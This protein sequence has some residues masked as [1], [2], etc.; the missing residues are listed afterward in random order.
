MLPSC[1]LTSST[2]YSCSW[3][4]YSD[5]IMTVTSDYSLYSL[6]TLLFSRTSGLCSLPYSSRLILLGSEVCWNYAGNEGIDEE[7]D[8]G[9]ERELNWSWPF[10]GSHGPS[11]GRI[12][13]PCSTCSCPSCPLTKVT[14]YQLIQMSY[15]GSLLIYVGWRPDCSRRWTRGVVQLPRKEMAMLWMRLVAIEKSTGPD[16]RYI[17]QI[18][19]LRYFLERLT[20]R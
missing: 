20:G 2:V 4:A 10:P 8:S 7:D 9:L 12:D 18:W 17:L 16:L 13:R 15:V 5:P 3:D 1:T 19:G 11:V 6:I 14:S